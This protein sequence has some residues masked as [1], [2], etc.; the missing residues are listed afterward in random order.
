[1]W[2]IITKPKEKL[3]NPMVTSKSSH[4]QGCIQADVLPAHHLASKDL[5]QR[6]PVQSALHSGVQGVK[7][8]QVQNYYVAVRDSKPCA[9]NCVCADCSLR[10]QLHT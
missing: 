1:M 6:P 9:N 2:F 4:C 3:K 5:V 10:W 7:R 8:L